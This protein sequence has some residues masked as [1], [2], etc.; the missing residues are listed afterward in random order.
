MAIKPHRLTDPQRGRCHRESE[1]GVR[2]NKYPDLS[3]YPPLLVSGIS[4]WLNPMGG[5]RQEG[6]DDVIHIPV[7]QF[8]EAQTSQRLGMGKSENHHANKEVANEYKPHTHFFSSVYIKK[9]IS[10]LR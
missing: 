4:H 7:D 9:K 3:L 8:P 6:P 5:H 10:L 1:A 2:W